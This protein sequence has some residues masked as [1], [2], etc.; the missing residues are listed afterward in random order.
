MKVKILVT[1]ILLLFI[2]FSKAQLNVAS[3]ITISILPGNSGAGLLHIKQDASINNTIMGNGLVLI[4]GTTAQ[5]IYGN[6][7][8]ANLTVSNAA[9]VSLNGPVTITGT[10]SPTAGTITTNGNLVVAANAAIIG[11]YS[12]LSGNTTIQQYVIGQRGWRI[13][14]NPFTSATN[15]TNTATASNIIIGTTSLASGLTDSRTFNNASNAWANVTG[16]TWAA[17][18]AYSLFIRGITS[19]LPGGTG[20]AY[21]NNPT[22]FIY[23]V[24]GTL[25]ANSVA[26]PAANP[27]N[28]SIIGNPYAAPVNTIAL[29]GGA[30]NGSQSYFVYTIS[31]S[32]TPQIKSGGW[33]AVLASDNVT[34]IPTL[35]AIAIKTAAG[36]SITNTDINNGGTVQNSLFGVTPV[37]QNIEL[38]VEQNGYYQDKTFV[39]F[40]TTA[41]AAGNDKNDLE[42]FYNDNVNVY[43]ITDNTHTRLAIDAR[44]VLKNIPLG[45]S[46]LNGDYNFK[47][48]NNN[49]ADGTT[50]TLKDHFLES[51]TNLQVGD[52]YPFTISTDT[53]SKGEHRFELFFS[54]K[55]T[56]I[57]IDNGLVNFT[58]TILGN[59]TGTNNLTV[60]IAGASVPIT[61]I[62]KDLNG[63]TLKTLKASNGTQQIN[64]GSAAKEMLLLQFSDGKNSIIKKAIKL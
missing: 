4:D 64:L 16:A 19:D 20:L 61:I 2:H 53:A 29:T 22:A 28:F 58:A 11:D 24:S 25:N 62:I 38:L 47:L 51:E 27:T 8:L 32:G 31:A 44:N 40:D 54:N 42:K 6:V 36:Y 1:S 55:A 23:S 5:N 26:V 41:T 30:S 18:T 3:G 15:I 12:L 43:T 52:I 10:L 17:N 14:N 45:I 49:L 9:G 37:I 39:R 13:F 35:G 50:L 21:N 57:P 60:Q 34:T 46:A 48:A 59:I 33:T 63:V 7:T 56:A